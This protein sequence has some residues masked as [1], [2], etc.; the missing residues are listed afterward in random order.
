MV[1]RLFGWKLSGCLF[2]GSEAS[3]VGTKH[4]GASAGK[5]ATG[6]HTAAS[7]SLEVLENSTVDGPIATEAQGR[8]I[9]LG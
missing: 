7:V 2:R 3:A 9:E 1:V 8:I 4:N 5:L 6:P